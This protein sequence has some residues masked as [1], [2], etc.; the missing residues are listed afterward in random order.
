MGRARSR[1]R[2][3]G[4]LLRRTGGLAGEENGREIRF[5]YSLR[6]TEYTTVDILRRVPSSHLNDGHAGLS[7]TLSSASCETIRSWSPHD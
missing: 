6:S 3:N 2:F 1:L 5:P 4:A 7:H